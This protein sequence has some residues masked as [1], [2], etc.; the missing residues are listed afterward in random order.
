[1]KIIKT[2]VFSIATNACI[3]RMVNAEDK[4]KIKSIRDV[5][6]R[7]VLPVSWMA[8]RKKFSNFLISINYHFRIKFIINNQRKKNKITDLL[9]KSGFICLNTYVQTYTY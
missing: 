3:T 4:K 5:L 7:L 9:W 8:I 6:L 1:M 2:P